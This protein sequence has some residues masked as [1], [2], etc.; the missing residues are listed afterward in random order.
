MAS[1]DKMLECVSAVVVTGG[2]SGIGKSFIEHM[3]RLRPSLRFCNLSR[4]RPELKTSE[5]NL[6]HVPCD[7]ADRGAFPQAV[8]EVLDFLNREVPSGRVLLVNNSGFG[9]YGHFP[10]P[11][12]DQL[13]AMLDVNIG[14]VV[15]LTAGLLPTLKARGGAIINVASTAAFQPT[16][17]L[18]TYGATK[19]F[20][21]H[22][23]LSLNEELRGTDVRSLAVCPGPT[24]T[25]FFRRAGF[26]G[27][28]AAGGMQSSTAVVQESLQALASGRALVVTGWKNRVM[29]AVSSKLPKAFVAR[30]ARRVLARTRMPKAG[31]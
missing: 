5:L 14:A 8:A 29:T 6:R 9:G 30:L 31:P 3:G 11:A 20:V 2:S 17:Y 21:L 22:W 25:D 7:F 27:G 4:T 18:A 15:R 13:F 10:E 28:K 12:E 24:A 1:I 16:P 19:A 23:S 26:D